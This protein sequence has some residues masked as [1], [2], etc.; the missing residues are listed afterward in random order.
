MFPSYPLGKAVQQS[1]WPVIFFFVSLSG[2]GINVM[3]A[4]YNDFGSVRSLLIIWK[5]LRRIG[6]NILSVPQWSH[7]ACLQECCFV[8]WIKG[9]CLTS[10]DESVQ[11]LSSSWFSFGGLYDSRDWSI[12]G[13]P[14]SW[15]IIVD[16]ILLRFF[17]FLWYQLFLLFNF[18]FYLGP[19]S[20]CWS[21]PEVW[22]LCPFK[23]M[24]LGFIISVFKISLIYL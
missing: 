4:S 18:L 3:V 12:L 24:A 16:S 17:V 8:F 22:R 20:S 23:K 9:Y 10:G 11:I 21:L 14:V 5:S 6:V 13:C 2:F 1:F 7:R 15:H 19:F